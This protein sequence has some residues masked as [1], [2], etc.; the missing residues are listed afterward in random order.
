[1]ET[2]RPAILSVL[3]PH[4]TM[5]HTVTPGVTQCQPR[6]EHMVDMPPCWTDDQ[7]QMPHS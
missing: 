3:L 7:S 5:G 6:G 2:L 4:S 1:M